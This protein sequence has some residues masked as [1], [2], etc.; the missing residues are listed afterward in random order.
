M[1]AVCGSLIEEEHVWN[2]EDWLFF[3]TE[4]DNNIDPYEFGEGDL[5]VH[6]ITIPSVAVALTN[7][8]LTRSERSFGLDGIDLFPNYNDLI[9]FPTLIPEDTNTPRPTLTPTPTLEPTDTPMPKVT[10]TNT[11]YEPIRVTA[12]PK[13]T[14]YLYDDLVVAQ[15][16]GGDTLVNIRN[17]DP[18]KDS[19]TSILR[20]FRGVG[21]A[22]RSAVGGGEGR[23]T[24]VSTGDLNNDGSPEIVLSFGP[25]L[26]PMRFIP[27]SSWPATRTQAKCWAIRLKRSPLEK[28]HP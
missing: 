21:G 3:S 18:E 14:D 10:P 20:S 27:T 22:F 11:P 2:M 7:F 19:V 23:Q 15:G 8:Q 13:H 26:R 12:T 5:L 28:V 4:L 17:L 6:D 24:Y 9:P 25:H 16:L 1:D